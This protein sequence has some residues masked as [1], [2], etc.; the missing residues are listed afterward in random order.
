MSVPSP[1]PLV[2]VVRSGRVE[3]VHFGAVAVVDSAGGRL[4][5]AGD[6]ATATFLR[7]SAK[8][9]QTLS[10]LRAGGREAFALGDP[11][12]ALISASHWGEPFHAELARQ[13]LERGGFSVDALRCGAHDPYDRSEAER[14]H[15]AGE[16]V[17]P[18]H[19]NCSG[20]HAGML[21]A[22]RRRGWDPASYTAPA[23]PLQRE[24][25]AT[26]STWTGVP[27]GEIGIGVDGC[28]APT[29]HLPLEGMAL[30][31]ARLLETDGDAWPL[32]PAEREHRDR[33]TGAMRRAPEYVGGTESPTTL[34]MRA[35]GGD[36]LAK[37]GA[38]AFYAMAAPPS[39]SATIRRALGLPPGPDRAVG[40]ALKVWDGGRRG[41]E[42]VILEALAQLGIL[43]ASL[44]PKLATQRH[45]TI[46]NVRGDTVGEV[47]AAF[48]LAQQG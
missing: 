35:A 8:P 27:T 46:R 44:P 13:L 2:H 15:D 19:N 28:S 14:L 33:I 29:F 1:A 18:L 36:L 45:P 22:C 30:A 32:D 39:A 11:E 4:G 21:L 40:I 34:L 6:P 37:E 9:F 24:I 12:I 17:T 38:E 16:A 10:L 47:V 5:A 26:L 43:P 23:H 48:R 41:R 42:V 3:S 7:S 25:L 20:K 31:F